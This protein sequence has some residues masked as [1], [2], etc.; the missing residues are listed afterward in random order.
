MT[1]NGWREG[2]SKIMDFERN[3]FGNGLLCSPFVQAFDKAMSE[4]AT[5]SVVLSPRLDS[6]Y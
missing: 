6:A 5:E 4:Y 1:R 2:E 3:H